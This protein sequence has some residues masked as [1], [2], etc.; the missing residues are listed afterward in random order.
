MR[1]TQD[2]NHLEVTI[3]VALGRCARR[4]KPPQGY[5]CR[6]GFRRFEKAAKLTDKADELSDVA[7]ELRH[8]AQSLEHDA[9]QLVA[10]AKPI[11][12]KGDQPGACASA[13]LRTRP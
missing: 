12:P 6:R 13:C 4:W 7:D 3:F 9:E 2:Q 10:P 5:V 1:W 11:A 8:Q